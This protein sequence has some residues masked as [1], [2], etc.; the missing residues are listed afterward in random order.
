MSESPK[1]PVVILVHGLWFGAWSLVL[2][3]RRLRRA[4]FEPRRFR[5]RTTRATLDE[6]ARALRRFIGPAADAPLHF[7][8]HSMG[9]LVTL[10]LFAA[11]AGLPAGRAVLLGSPLA[12][13]S[14]ARKAARI[15]GGRH[16]LGAARSTL[17][18][19]FPHLPAGREIG[20][21]AGS[22]PLGLGWL[23]GG[24]GGP[25]DG[26]VTIVETR[27]AGLREHLVLPVEFHLIGNFLNF[28]CQ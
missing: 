6:H 2:L 17:E 14:V 12:G 9:G 11:D 13:S 21:I 7:V 15:P 8:A 27:A 10:R 16:L 22:K 4:G 28:Y 3:A 20:M 24:T 18:S 5:Y 25:G 23:V 19:G 1:P 26:T